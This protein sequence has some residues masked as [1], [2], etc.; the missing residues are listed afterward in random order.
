MDGVTAVI[1]VRDTGGL[2]QVGAME[3][4]RIRFW[5]YSE[6]KLSGLA[7]GLDVED[8]IKRGVK[9][10]AQ[11]FSLSDEENGVEFSLG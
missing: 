3:R 4:V 8:E 11:I 10:D 7:G 9:N 5:L 1:Q 2:D 6:V